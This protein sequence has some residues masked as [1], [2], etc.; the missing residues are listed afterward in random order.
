MI[1]SRDKWKDDFKEFKS[2]LKK[3]KDNFDKIMSLSIGLH[4]FT[5][6]TPENEQRE[7]PTYE[8]QLWQENADFTKITPQK[9]YSAAWHVWHSARIEDITCA[10]L[11]LSEDEVLDSQNYYEKINVPFRHTGN[12]MDYSE[13]E[14]FNKSIN[15]DELRMYRRKVAERTVNTL[16]DL[17]F[18]EFNSKFSASDIDKISQTKSVADADSWL[19]EYWGKKKVSGIIA[20]PFTRHLMVHINSAFRAL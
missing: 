11:L 3:P 17:T 12:S 16:N 4:A 8:D 14:L 7:I 13:M 18:G 2:L 10:R 9:I 19:L 20:M 6:E 1:D 5:H 15:I